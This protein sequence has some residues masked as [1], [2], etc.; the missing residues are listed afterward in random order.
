MPLDLE[1]RGKVKNMQTPHRKAQANQV[2]ENVN[3]FCLF[4]YL[5]RSQLS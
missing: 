5:P 1:A 2:T 3:T 4:Q